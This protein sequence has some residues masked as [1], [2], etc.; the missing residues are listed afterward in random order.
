[1]PMSYLID[2][3]NLMALN[4]GWHRDREAARRRLVHDLA[5]FVARTRTKVR[6]VFDGWP[7]E[8]FPEGRRFKSVLVLYARPGSDADARIK[9]LVARSSYR[10]DM[11]VVTSDRALQSFVS[12]K[13]ARV[14]S[15]GKFRDLIRD[16]LKAET[17]EK[18]DPEPVDVDDWL[19]FFRNS[20]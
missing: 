19:N 15:S 16:T 20:H 12:A 1:M 10:R 9:E 2:G 11:V 6:V 17:S 5:A 8:E 7:D 18:S 3:N 4:V 13:G 14:L